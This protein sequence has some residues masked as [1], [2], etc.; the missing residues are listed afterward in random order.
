MRSLAALKMPDIYRQI[1]KAVKKGRDVDRRIRALEGAPL[2]AAPGDADAIVPLTGDREFKVRAA[3]YRALGATGSPD[4]V[5]AVLRGIRDKEPAV[6]VAAAA[7]R[8]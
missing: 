2:L 4:A 3:A 8:R 6:R 1:L 7:R 5:N